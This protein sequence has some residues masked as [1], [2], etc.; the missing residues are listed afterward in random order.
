MRSLKDTKLKV[1]KARLIRVSVGAI[2][3]LSSLG[4]FAQQDPMFTHYMFNM[5]TVNPGSVG[6][7]DYSSVMNVNRY[8]WVGFDGAPRTHTL[9]ADIPIQ[10]IHCGA[11][12]TYVMDKVGPEKTNNFYI[13][14]A[15]HLKVADN[16]KLGLGLKAGFRVFSSSLTNL[17]N[18]ADP[19]F[20]SNI[21]GKI[22]PNFG[23][24]AFLYNDK[25]YVG[26]SSPKILN[27]RYVN[28]VNGG[29]KRHY[30]L[31]S[32]Y[33]LPIKTDLIFKPSVYIKYIEGAPVSFDITAN[34]LL[35]NTVWFGVMYRRGDAIGF[36]TQLELN[37]RFRFGYTYDLTL[38][39][40]RTVSKGTHEIMLAYQ[41]GFD[42]KKSRSHWLF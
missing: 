17:T 33:V 4:L 23:V 21:N 38:S 31:V 3:S 41:F 35:K 1:M 6:H 22:T 42:E 19:E 7:T 36:L 32:G 29:E 24:G 10:K 34:F 15:Y 12:F 14:Y 30:F 16:L 9:N 11:G 13:D 26:L 40:I 5:S 8:Q 28:S 25:F 20:A 27:H 39:K 2:F 37:D 18:E